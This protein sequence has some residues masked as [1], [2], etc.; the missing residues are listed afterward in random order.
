[1]DGGTEDLV[2]AV[3]ALTTPLSEEDSVGHCLFREAS[4]KK[5]TL[6]MRVEAED[7][8]LRNEES[9]GPE[10]KT[11][12]KERTL[13]LDRSNQWYYLFFFYLRVR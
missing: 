6:L 8:Q 10:N 12:T 9:V 5:N 7:I 13:F 11:K 1:M 3:V 2:G 4:Q